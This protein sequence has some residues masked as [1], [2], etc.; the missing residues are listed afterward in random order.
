ME[1]LYYQ[2]ILINGKVVEFEADCVNDED[3]YYKFEL[4]GQIVSE[5]NKTNIAG[6]YLYE[7]P[8]EEDDDFC[9]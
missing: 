3:G 9:D 4:D 7:E 2:V 1:R 6:Y 8:S 5:F